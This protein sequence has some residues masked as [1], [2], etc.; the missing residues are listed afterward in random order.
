V[1]QRLDDWFNPIVVKELRQAVNGKFVAAV[2]MLLL[3][4]Q[5]AALGI[6]IIAT[7][8]FSS[9]V[10]A[11][12]DAFMILQTILQAVCLLFVPAYTGV[13]LAL[14]RSD[15]NVDLLFVTTIKPVA[16][17][18]GK[19]FSALTITVLIFS[20][21]M[22][23]MVFTYWLRGIDLPSIFVLLALSF[24][25]VVV[26][27][28]LA[29]FI[30][31][32]PS[33]RIFKVLLTVGVLIIF[34]YVFGMAVTGSF[35]LLTSG[36][37]SRLGSWDFWGPAAAV[38]VIGLAVMGL[39]F[40][41]SVALITPISA[42]RAVAVRAYVTVVW[43]V[44]GI[45]SAIMAYVDR[46]DGALAVWGIL[47]A[48]VFSGG[49]FVAVS[50]REK[51][52]PRVTR[53]IPKGAGQRVLAFLLFSGGASGVAWSALMSALTF[54]IV[55]ALPRAFATLSG[56]SAVRETRVWLIGLPLYAF[57]YSMTA[58]LVRRRLLSRWLGPKYTWGV[59]LVLLCAGCII[60]FLVGY[61][62]FFGN[63]DR[64][65]DIAA[66]L[67][68]NPFALGIESFRSVY[69]ATAGLWALLALLLNLSWLTD[70]VRAFRPPQALG[71]TR[72]A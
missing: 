17:I 44:S 48:L 23:F 19:L 32:I 55:S 58:L 49:F 21:C 20:A 1:K 52:G 51:L 28:Q 70:Q 2:L 65:E 50:E 35:Y 57:S 14:E 22:P 40:F 29:T 56:G 38:L 16:I 34:L 67:I 69:L 3:V 30:A 66:W 31:S 15:H 24:L 18:G 45:F 39:L 27:I 4:I 37:G 8:D 36:V 62:A 13:R 41:A 60:P 72:D 63:W 7:G 10:T 11:G 46:D 71:V 6:Y 25:E 33:G 47:S 68:L 53:A 42:N 5:L 9:R 59:G 54:V 61:L 43:L 12:R 26:C 64:V